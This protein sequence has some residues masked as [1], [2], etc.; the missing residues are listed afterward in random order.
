VAEYDEVLGYHL[1]QSFRYREQLAPVDEAARALGERAAGRLSSA[2]RRAFG[3]GDMPVAAGLL[4]RAAALLPAG[5]AARGELNL[6]L[7]VALCE[8]G[9]ITRAESVFE[10]AAEAAS[11]AGDAKVEVQASLERSYW[12]LATNPDGRTADLRALAEEAIRML[13]REGDDRGLARAWGHLGFVHAAA[14]QWTAAAEAYES[15][16]AHA[17]RAGDSQA[18]GE[19]LLW[20]TG[21]LHYGPTPVRQGIRRLA[22]ALDRTSGT[23]AGAPAP[24]L[25][26]S[27]RALVEAAGLAALEAMNGDFGAARARCDRAAALLE[28]LGQTLKLAVVRQ[29]SGWVEL[30]AGDAEAAERELRLGFDKLE[31]IGEKGYLSTTAALLAEATYAQARYDAADE[32]ASVA[33]ESAAQDDVVTHT[34]WRA[35]RGKICARRGDQ[36][37]ADRLLRE[38]LELSRQTDDLNLQADKLLDLSEALSVGGRT[39]EITPLLTDALALYEAKGNVVAADRVRDALDSHQPKE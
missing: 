10:A 8:L 2:G 20:L 37:A 38:A 36:G 24:T 22:E 16:L 4:E 3:R 39:G 25:D 17:R 13:G 5:H 32:F 34:L 23:R 19:L 30:L 7:G 27:S 31:E 29:V 26:L 6:S 21:A 14:C 33:S 28:E 1:E 35:T 18:E 15:G 11:A 9:E 12:S